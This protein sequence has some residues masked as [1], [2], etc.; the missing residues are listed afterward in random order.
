[1]TLKSHAHS[2]PALTAVSGVVA[3]LFPATTD[4]NQPFDRSYGS[5]ERLYQNRSSPSRHRRHPTHPNCSTFGRAGTVPDEHGR[6]TSDS[7]DGRC[8]RHPLR[9][10][11]RR[12]GRFW[13]VTAIHYVHALLLVSVSA[14]GVF[15]VVMPRKA[16]HVSCCR[17]I[18]A[19]HTLHGRL[20]DSN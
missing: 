9:Y 7:S 17:D 10:Q 6:G 13:Y 8:E 19:R 15:F 12:D 18:V 2:P 5:K 4:S 11:R 14:L 3:L 1:M 20:M 16:A